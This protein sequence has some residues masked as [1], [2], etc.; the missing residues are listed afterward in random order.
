MSD[1][2]SSLSLESSVKIG[3]P[4]FKVYICG[5]DVSS[6]VF[7]VSVNN[8]GGSAE[9]A[10]GTCTISLVNPYDKYIITRSD[11]MS[12]I[13]RREGKNVDEESF[14]GTWNSIPKETLEELLISMGTNNISKVEE[15]L[16]KLD[17]L[18]KSGSS[19]N[20]IEFIIKK[21]AKGRETNDTSSGSLDVKLND[22]IKKE[23]INKK[24][25]TA[26]VILNMKNEEEIFPV[27]PFSQGDSIFHAND[28]VRVAFQDPFDPSQWYWK[29]SGFVDIVTEN[30]GE[31]RDSR[32]VITCTDVTKLVRYSMLTREGI[33]LDKVIEIK[34]ALE[35]DSDDKGVVKVDS[36]GMIANAQEFAYYT[37][38][39][40]LSTIFFGRKNEVAESKDAFIG[41]LTSEKADDSLIKSFEK[42]KYFSE[43]IMDITPIK[44][45][46]SGAQFKKNSGSI[47]G[48]DYYVYG[49]TPD[50]ID[51][52][53][54]AYGAK[55]KTLHEF[56]EIIHNR[57]RPSDLK[58]MRNTV[59]YEDS[60]IG[61]NLEVVE[62]IGSDI[63]NYPV[64][65]GR[66]FYYAPTGLEAIY[67]ELQGSQDKSVGGF[68][69]HSNFRDKLS[70]LYDLAD[71]LE[72]RFYAS[73]KGDVIFEIAMY[74][75]S[76]SDFWE[77]GTDSKKVL[78][79]IL[80]SRSY[81]DIFQN[82]YKGKYKDNVS[83]S[84]EL[85]K[86][87]DLNKELYDKNFDY[88]KHYTIEK[89]DQLGF[90]NTFT[91]RNF[92]TAYR[93]MPNTISNYDS[94]DNKDINRYAWSVATNWAAL[95]GVRINEGS[96]WRVIDKHEGA[97]LYCELY[98]NKMNAEAR[99]AAI[100]I[101]PR[102][103]LMPNRPIFW[104]EKNMYA[105]IVSITD[106]ISWGS[107][108]STTLNVNHIRTWSGERDDY[109]F[110][111]FYHFMYKDKPMNLLDILKKG[112]NSLDSKT[113]KVTVEQQHEIDSAWVDDVY[114]PR[115]IDADLDDP[116][117][118]F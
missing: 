68:N 29:F 22:S 9:R 77:K 118:I 69:I 98:M 97:G 83:I 46:P 19:S 10:A 40:T 52:L 28:P 18:N 82:D 31:N 103:G 8:P 111:V 37:M 49:T 64:G 2:L 104:R 110:P 48:V 5:K 53:D 55:Y 108:V 85:N 43:D 12:I 60:L 106:S 65:G 41:K 47:L 81:Y 4:N 51:P 87:V 94:I 93:C 11:F 42:K 112:V 50:D 99:N 88:I 58:D 63:E 74:D 78:E 75:F 70:F 79:Y 23:I 86:S 35:G 101:I 13:N 84:D 56:T 39:E 26:D 76:P 6:D 16:G 57:V 59:S 62:I 116:N 73:P 89:N 105:C 66:V 36:I 21:I 102:F 1:L 92:V 72:F 20:F 107:G 32:I 115:F 3:I 30:S 44:A 33:V 114:K 95:L 15:I 71:N 67:T 7:E 100:K 109:G 117:D 113:T 34:K 90:S 45:P 25:A 27:Y 80:G 54:K 14:E 61:S 38:L 24:L 17:L 96:T 91:D